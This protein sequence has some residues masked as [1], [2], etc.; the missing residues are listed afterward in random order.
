M[1]P[2]KGLDEGPQKEMM[3]GMQ[4]LIGSLA[5]FQAWSLLTFLY[6][7]GGDYREALMR[8]FDARRNN[9]SHAV[10]T[11]VT[12]KGIDMDELEKAWMAWIDKVL[13]AE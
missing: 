13:N 10:V 6:E 3:Q 7:S 8:C 2:T 11:R 5:Y 4:G 1:F 9:K 12:F